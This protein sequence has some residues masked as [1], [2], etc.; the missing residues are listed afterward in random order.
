MYN[1]HQPK[2]LKEVNEMV[3]NDCDKYAKQIKR[4]LSLSWDYSWNHM[5]CGSAGTITIFDNK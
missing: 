2:I 4:N 1:R 3:S 5:Y